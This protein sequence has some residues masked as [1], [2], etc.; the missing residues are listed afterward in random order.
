MMMKTN[1]V[2]PVIMMK[3]PANYLQ[4]GFLYAVSVDSGTALVPLPVI[5][6]YSKLLLYGAGLCRAWV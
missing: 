6:S 2:M 3:Q 4:N 5:L 1:T